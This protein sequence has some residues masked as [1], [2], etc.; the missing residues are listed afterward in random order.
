MVDEYRSRS[1]A[2]WRLLPPSTYQKPVVASVHGYC[3][4]GGLDLAD[5]CDLIIAA[6]DTE[7]GLSESRFGAILMA[8]LPWTL[9]MRK[10][11]EL[12][13]TSQ[14]ISAE[15]AHSLGMVNR[16]VA[17]AD[18]ATETQNLVGTIAKM[19]AET[20]YFGK[21]AVN[22]AFEISG[23]LSAVRQ[24]YDLNIFAHLTDG[25][26]RTWGRIRKERGVKAAFEWRD[27]NF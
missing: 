21:L 1:D 15:R 19:P 12:I 9:G 10:A 3:I 20:L 5:S 2:V 4:A 6:D 27:R 14:N 25:A 7:F 16:V 8:F 24:S 22:R 13:F 18:L 11:K 23:I 17:R 26:M